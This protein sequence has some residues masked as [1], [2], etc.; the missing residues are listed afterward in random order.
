MTGPVPAGIVVTAAG[1]V[2]TAGEEGAVPVQPAVKRMHM[3]IHNSR[4]IIDRQAVWFMV[5]TSTPKK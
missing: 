4:G 5:K 3:R 1:E 2:C